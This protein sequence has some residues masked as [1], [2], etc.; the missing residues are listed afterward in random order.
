MMP[1]GIFALAGLV[2]ALILTPALLRLWSRFRFVQPAASDLHHT[3]QHPV[4]RCG[5]LV[6]ALAFLAA[7][8]Y[9]LL[10]NPTQ[11][12]T[13]RLG[14]PI[15]LGA[16][17]MFGLGFAD[18]VRRLGAKKKLFGQVFI[19]SLIVAA[20]I[21]IESV[22]VPYLDMAVPLGTWGLLFT[23]FWIVLFTNLINLIDGTDGLAGGICLM[24]MVLLIFSV[25]S[26][27]ITLMAAVMAGALLGFLRFN[28][29]PAR[30]Y[31]GDGGA[32]LLGSLIGILTVVSCQKGTVLAALIAPLFVLT[33]PILDTFLAVVRR[34]LYGLPLFRPD[35]GHLH[36]RLM[37]VGLS[38][39]QIVLRLHAITL[40]FLMLAFAS[41]AYGGR[42]TPVLV[43]VAF[44]VL[45]LL[46]RQFDFSRAWLKPGPTFTRSIETRREVQYALALGAWL[47]LEATRAH[48][49]PDLWKDFSFMIRKLGF[50]TVRLKFGDAERSWHGLDTHSNDT[51]PHQIRQVLHG[52]R[53]GTLE[54]G[55]SPHLMDERLFELL[56]ELSI[57][58]WLKSFQRLTNLSQGTPSFNPSVPRPS[59][60]RRARF[61]IPALIE[62]VATERSRALDAGARTISTIDSTTIHRNRHQPALNI[63]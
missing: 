2:L 20:G 55:A 33:L 10:Q 51:P 44:L 14:W 56:S 61:Y 31:L 50:S 57:E 19:A 39:Q 63:L 8:S 21:R 47:E 17:A 40:L 4:P 54:L 12:S 34:G 28:W 58:A 6:L 41:F 37:R 7:G 36:H 38:R 13:G 1:I 15:L 59:A 22:W 25:Q 48:S 26:S 60:G 5:G 35:R 23:V 43:G 24:L 46:A 29:P 11:S 3:H 49:L 42:L 27:D 16:L 53:A 45:I 18:D 30:V 32:Y 62:T 9:L 52:G